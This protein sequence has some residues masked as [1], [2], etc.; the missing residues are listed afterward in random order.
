M[1][2]HHKQNC[3]L[4]HSAAEYCFADYEKRKHFRCPTC[5]EFQ[6]TDTAEV[7]LNAAP[8]AWRAEYS[9]KA[10]EVVPDRVLCISVPSGMRSAGVAYEALRGES[11]ERKDLPPCR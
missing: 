8:A 6:I 1:I 9:A 10:R 2:Q 5:V 4:C 11:M 3:P 7:K